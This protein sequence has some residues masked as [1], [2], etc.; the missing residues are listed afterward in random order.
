MEV[1]V[2]SHNDVGLLGRTAAK[3][4]INLLRAKASAAHAA[5]LQTQVAALEAKLSNPTKEVP[6][7]LALKARGSADK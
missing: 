5:K 7:K 6:F 1:Q 4:K 2:F 3:R